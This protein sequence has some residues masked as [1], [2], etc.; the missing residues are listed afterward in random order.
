MFAKR[1]NSVGPK[2]DWKSLVC[3][4][5][6]KINDTFTDVDGSLWQIQIDLDTMTVFAAKVQ[7]A[8]QPRRLYNGH[9]SKHGIGLG[10]M[11]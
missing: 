3:E 6:K 9:C 2:V 5:K 8:P 11:K 1:S 7:D 10:K 4:G